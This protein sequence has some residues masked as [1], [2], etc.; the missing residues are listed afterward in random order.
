MAGKRF[1]GDH[2]C[3][4]DRADGSCALAMVGRLSEERVGELAEDI[5]TAST[6]RVVPARPSPD[7]RSSRPGA[8]A[9]AVYRRRRHQEREAWRPGW[10]RRAG[11]VAVAAGGVGLLTGLAVGA[12]LGWQLALL[13][14]LVTGWRLRFRPSAGTR[15]WRRQAVM[16][17]ATAGALGPLEQAG[18]LVL[19]DI[20]LPGWPA[21]LDHLV[22]GS[23]GIWV[24][25]SWQRGRLVLLRN[26]SS[27]WSA[28][29]ATAGPLRELHW[30]ATAIA[31]TLAAGTS[32]PVRPLLCVHGGARPG[33]ARSLQG[34][35]VATPRQLAD[36]V[37]QPPPPP[38]REIERGHRARSGGAPPGGLSAADPRKDP[39]HAS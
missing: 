23:T 31:D 29:G 18:Y 3:C 36:V 35:R 15:V 4:R 30:Q 32:I 38:P 34:L 7:A 20:T 33:T 17:R 39:T 9:E 22:V 26:R 28:C 21:G 11:I 16:Q 14:A 27:P 1:Q 13:V 25:G 5:W 8:S 37:R 2:G 19:H 6:G 12:W 10:P 24:L